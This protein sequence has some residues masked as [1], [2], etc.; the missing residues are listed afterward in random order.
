M[1][2]SLTQMKLI[3]YDLRTVVWEDGIPERIPYDLRTVVWENGIPETKFLTTF[4][5]WSGR[6]AETKFLPNPF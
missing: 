4:A 1:T 3:P 2:S 6:M 5:L